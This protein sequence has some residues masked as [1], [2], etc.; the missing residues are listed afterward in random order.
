LVTVL[1][2]FNEPGQADKSG[3]RILRNGRNLG[4]FEEEIPPLLGSM[5]VFRVTSNCWHG[6][7]RFVGERRSLQLNYL[8]G[9]QRAGKHQRIRRWF[10]HLARKLKG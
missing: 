9:V 2:Y 4:D 1:M 10:G 6:Y 3:L 7:R 8:S 5:V